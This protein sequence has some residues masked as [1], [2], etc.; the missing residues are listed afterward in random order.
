MSKI[1]QKIP[2]QSGMST[3]FCTFYFFA[4]YGGT[5]KDKG[6]SRKIKSNLFMR[7]SFCRIV[8]LPSPSGSN[9][10]ENLKSDLLKHGK[11][12]E[13]DVTAILVIYFKK[14]I[15]STFQ[16]KTAKRKIEK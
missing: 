11:T 9:S 7:R 12:T 6:L 1:C 15:F 2:F 3:F 5:I 14:M 16:L 10:I 8:E 13:F 4:F